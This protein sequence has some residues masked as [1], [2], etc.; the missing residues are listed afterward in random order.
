[1]FIQSALSCFMFFY[2]YTQSTKKGGY[3]SQNKPSFILST[4]TIGGRSNSCGQSILWKY[5]S[6]RKCHIPCFSSDEVMNAYNRISL[7]EKDWADYYNFKE[8]HIAGF[9]RCGNTNL[10]TSDFV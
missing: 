10:T 7:Q 9:E 1:M 4:A 6:N 3:L 2:T 5:N 8:L